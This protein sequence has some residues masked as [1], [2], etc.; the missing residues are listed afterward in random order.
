MGGGDFSPIP[1]LFG[2]SGLPEYKRLGSNPIQGF[3]HPAAFLLHLN[4]PGELL[5]L[6][7]QPKLSL[8]DFLGL[9]IQ[10]IDLQNQLIQRMTEAPIVDQLLL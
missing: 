7:Y 1:P 6:P 4:P 5:C 10:V 9:R 2:R 3:P 8:D